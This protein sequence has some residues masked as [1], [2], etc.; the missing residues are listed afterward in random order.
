[1]LNIN[2]IC[3]TT[4]YFETINLNLNVKL[5]ANVHVSEKCV[6]LATPIERVTML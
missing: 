6:H 1:M 4:I 5:N 3:N 2:L